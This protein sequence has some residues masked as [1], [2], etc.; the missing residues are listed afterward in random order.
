MGEKRWE[1]RAVGN[2]RRGDRKLFVFCC[3]ITGEFR[4]LEFE[5]DANLKIM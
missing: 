2:G 4:F 3:W 1:E 5:N